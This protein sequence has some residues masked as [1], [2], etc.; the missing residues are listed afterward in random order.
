M[1]YLI[2]KGKHKA[3]PRPF[4]VWLG[5]YIW[6]WQASFD[7]SAVYAVDPEDDTNKLVGVGFLP[8]HHRYSVRVG[9]RYDF[10][11]DR[12]GLYFYAY[13]EG[14]LINTFL[15][16]VEIGETFTIDI[17]QNVGFRWIQI[18]AKSG[19]FTKDIPVQNRR[20][21]SYLLNP[22]FGG[23]APAQKDIRITVNRII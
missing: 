18:S 1:I 17:A 14:T 13:Q 10:T 19:I 11:L 9:W 23:N 4:K 6:Q 2:K 8:W 16:H 5:K 21:F 22:Y 20:Y 12:I 3:R 7:R 15:C